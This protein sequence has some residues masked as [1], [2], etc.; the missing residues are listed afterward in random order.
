MI[1][2]NPILFIFLSNHIN[3]YLFQEHKYVSRKIIQF[4]YYYNPPKLIKILLFI[5]RICNNY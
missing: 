4:D 1:D 2:F 5:F 3:I